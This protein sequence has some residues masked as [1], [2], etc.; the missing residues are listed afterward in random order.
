MARD[1]P[2]AN[3]DYLSI[4]SNAA[5]DVTGTL[6]TIHAWVNLDVNNVGQ[7][8]AGKHNSSG[9]AGSQFVCYITGA[10]KVSAQIGDGA[11]EDVS[12]GT[13]T[14]TTGLWHP[15]GAVKNGTGAG[16]L[17]SFLD[18]VGEGAITSAKSI[19]SSATAFT[20]GR[21][22]AAV[23]PMNG[24]IAEVAIWA[25]GLSDGEMA[26]LAKG[27]S[28][29]R[30]RRSSLRGYWPLFGVAYPEADL[31]GTPSNLAQNGSVPAF[32]HAPV[33]RL[34]PFAG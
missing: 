21:S 3:S 4:A 12:A 6:L 25:A 27:V 24:R 30:I 8:V 10:G 18:G 22:G 5:L 34:A 23:L 1:F 31:A 11:A 28:P 13:T 33:G 26:A 20:V 19:A 16:S 7:F 29:L 2:G 15:V 14:V 32:N 17:K 9:G